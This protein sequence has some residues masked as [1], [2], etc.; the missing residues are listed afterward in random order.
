MISRE[1]AVE[2]VESCLERERPGWA[3]ARRIPEPAADPI[4][5]PAGPV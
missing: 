4:E 2:L 3:W 1:R 5:T